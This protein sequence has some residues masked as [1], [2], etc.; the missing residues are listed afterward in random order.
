MRSTNYSSP[1]DIWA[2]GCIMAEIYTLRPLFP[3]NSEIDEIYK[4]C[5]VLGTPSKV[6]TLT[7][8]GAKWAKKQ[9]EKI[10]RQT[11]GQIDLPMKKQGLVVR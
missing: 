6:W 8:F 3:G 9:G 5:S 11:E 4:V 2:C 1:I 10:N 7:P